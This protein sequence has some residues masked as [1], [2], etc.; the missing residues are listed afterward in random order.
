M[1]YLVLML[2]CTS[3]QAQ[4]LSEPQF[5]LNG[6]DYKA[7]A[8]SIND[9]LRNVAGDIQQ[10]RL[11][12]ADSSADITEASSPSWTGAH[13]FVNQVQFDKSV[14]FKSTVTLGPMSYSTGVSTISKMS[15][16]WMTVASTQAFNAVCSTFT[17]LSPDATYRLRWELYKVNGAGAILIRWHPD[18]GTTYKFAID[19][20]N[21]NAG[22]ASQGASNATTHCLVTGGT[23][24]VGDD[25]HSFGH[26]I[27]SKKPLSP[28]DWFAYGQHTF[29]DDN[30][31]MHTNTFSCLLDGNGDPTSVMLMTG[32]TGGGKFTGRLYLD[33]L[34]DPN[35]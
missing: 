3:V 32:I 21:T 14:T 16:V 18:A 22:A 30:P 23:A 8:I 10:L 26:I 4:N 7:D 9:M 13:R 31:F 25:D 27:F 24:A 19:G 29:Q 15:N 5:H 1:K 28:D 34:I 35:R 20:I 17:G 12:S 6:E 33:M 11:L 2:L